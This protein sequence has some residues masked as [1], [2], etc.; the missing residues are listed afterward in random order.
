MPRIFST[1][2]REAIRRTLIEAG[3]KHF[4][5]YGLRRTKVEELAR[6][7]GIAKGTFYNFFESKE[8]L[9]LEIYDE[10]E[11]RLDGQIRE[12]LCRHEDP[13]DA[14]QA[15]MLFSL[16][17]MKQDSLLVQ[18]QRTGEYALL[19]R[20]VGKDKLARHQENDVGF[21]ASLL[22]ALRAKGAHPVVDPRVLAAVLRAVVMLSFHAR[23]IGEEL[24]APAMDLI[25]G[26]VAD[27]VAMGGKI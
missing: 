11:A 10:E 9:C 22:E 17:V 7:A 2:D 15:V 27:R 23:E 12:V 19:G 16:D 8:D 6:A 13:R 14:L 21:A 25:L 26:A 20:G 18:L 5:R 24:F 4:L 1:E 3:R